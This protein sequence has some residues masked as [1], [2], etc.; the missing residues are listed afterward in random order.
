MGKLCS[1][2]FGFKFNTTI[3][4]IF[5]LLTIITFFLPLFSISCRNQEITLSGFELSFGKGIGSYRQDG[6]IFAGLIILPSAALLAL[7]FFIYKTK[8]ILLFKTVFLIIPIFNIFAI[9]VLKAI[10]KAAILKKIAE[11]D[12]NSFFANLVNKS[13][14]IKYGFVLYIIFNAVV[15]VFASINYFVK[16]E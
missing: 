9:F 14:N 10:V 13:M 2:M 3:I 7:S 6:N 1:D 15:F 4:K 12:V 5:L 11:F 8:K 16:R